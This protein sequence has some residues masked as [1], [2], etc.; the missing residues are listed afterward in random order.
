MFDLEKVIAGCKKNKRKSQIALYEHYSSRL[1]GICA[2]YVANTSEAEDILQDAFIK[3]F[4]NIQSYTGQGHF[5]G[6]MKKVVVNTAITHFNREKKNY[7]H[8]EI[9]NV[10]EDAVQLELSPD[11][12]YD[13]VELNK[14]LTTMPEGYRLIFN[15][16]AIEGYKHKEIA[17]KLNIEESTSKSQYLRA[18]QWII[19]EMKK[20]NW[21]NE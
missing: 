6:W 9:E 21:V 15:L 19:K 11:K 3:I 13:F 8:E 7:Y 12:E 17:E 5:E 2:R 18:K 20:L 4:K 1:L 10:N 16:Y 14:M